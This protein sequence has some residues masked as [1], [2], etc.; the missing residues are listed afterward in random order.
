M[1]TFKML[2]LSISHPAALSAEQTK[3]IEEALNK[4]KDWLR[5]APNCWLIWTSVEP[6]VWADRL[7]KVL[8]NEYDAFLFV[9]VNLENRGGWLIDDAWKWINKERR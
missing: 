3:Q 5:Y 9:E 4:A 1:A 7:H 6:R 8:S 2:H